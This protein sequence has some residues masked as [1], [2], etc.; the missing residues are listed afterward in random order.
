[1]LGVC[2]RCGLLWVSSWLKSTVLVTLQVAVLP[3]LSL[4]FLQVCPAYWP[5]LYSHCLPSQRPLI[6]LE[7]PGQ[8]LGWAVR[9]PG[10]WLA[11]MPSIMKSV[12]LDPEGKA[13]AQWGSLLGIML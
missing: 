1:M 10:H 9:T 6:S 13:R 2:A 8:Q 11:C 3:A 4:A 12:N 7:D 5:E